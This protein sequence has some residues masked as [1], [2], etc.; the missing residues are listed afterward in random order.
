MFCVGTYF[1]GDSFYESIGP[2]VVRMKTEILPIYGFETFSIL[3]IIII[4]DY[5]WARKS[6]RLQ[7]SIGQFLDAFLFSQLAYVGYIYNLIMQINGIHA[8]KDVVLFFALDIPMAV[9]S[10]PLSIYLFNKW[11]KRIRTDELDKDK[12]QDFRKENNKII[13]DYL[14]F[15]TFALAYALYAYWLTHH[16]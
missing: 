13:F 15:W 5:Y 1:G 14:L 9:V 3:T 16:V 12:D 8:F 7:V 2:Q 4:I 10:I 6:I 11:I